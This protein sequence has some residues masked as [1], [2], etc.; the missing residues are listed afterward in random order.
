MPLKSLYTEL[1]NVLL[2]GN[3]DLSH[4]I[5][6]QNLNMLFHHVLG[7]SS[8]DMILDPDKIVTDERAQE[9]RRIVHIM[10]HDR[11]PLSRILGVREFWGLAFDLSPETLDPRA[12]SESLIEAVLRVYPDRTQPYRIVDAGTG[13]GCLMI[14]LLSEYPNAH[15]I[16]IDYAWGACQ[17]AQH[18]AQKHEVKDRLLVVQGDWLSA[19]ISE[20]FIDIFISNP[21]YIP[22]DVVSNLDH[23]V[24]HYDPAAALDGGDDGFMAYDI[25]LS[26]LPPLMKQGSSGFF[27]IGYDQQSGIK[28]RI[29]SKKTLIFQEFHKDIMGIDRVAQFKKHD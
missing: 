10:R 1:K 22:H 15:G 2:A 16:A 20:N 19:L 7:L 21:P 26:Q 5:I 8:V 6:Q 28:Q 18:N 13:T 4:Q 24:T 12:D 27:E 29:E 23:S 9:L 25:L 3:A 17:M 14:A 11:K